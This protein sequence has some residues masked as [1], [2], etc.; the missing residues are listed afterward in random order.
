METTCT[1]T[2]DEFV[3]GD[4]TPEVVTALGTG[5][6]RMT[7]RFEGGPRGALGH[8][9]QLLLDEASGVG[10]YVAT[11]SSDGTVD[12]RRGTFNFVH[13]ATTLGHGERLHELFVIVPSSGTGELA[14]ITGTGAL[15]IDADGTHRITLDYELG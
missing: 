13:S 6:A 2:V 4:W 1:F 7:K 9:V 12:G 11:E 5:H 10:T 14:G 15:V 8:A 3:P